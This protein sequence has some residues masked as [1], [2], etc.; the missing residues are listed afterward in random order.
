MIFPVGIADWIKFMRRFLIEA[1]TCDV[2]GKNF[3]SGTQVI[4]VGIFI[5]QFEDMSAVGNHGRILL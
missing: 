5:V 1:R 2:I 4:G 3:R